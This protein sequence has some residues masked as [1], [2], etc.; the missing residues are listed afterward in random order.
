MALDELYQSV[1]LD[2]SK[3]PRNFRTI[4]PADRKERGHNPLCGDEVTLYL[5]M[6][7][8]VIADIAFQGQGCAIS[9]A[10]ASLLTTAVKGKTKA[11]ALELFTR[12]HELVTGRAPSDEERKALGKLAVFQGVAAYPIRVKCASM[13][14]HTLKGALEQGGTGA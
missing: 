9:K 1:I 6:D 14:W 8:D 3:S 13:A 2:H 12:V 11:E 10:S 7:G 5:T 4:E